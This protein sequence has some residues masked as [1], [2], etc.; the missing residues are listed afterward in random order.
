MDKRIIVNAS[1][2]DRTSKKSNAFEERGCC[3]IA[4]MYYSVY[5]MMRK[6]E[7]THKS[8][9]LLLLVLLKLSEGFVFSTFKTESNAIGR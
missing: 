2:I 4:E 3:V 9:F 7:Y 6:K 1:G 5:V 8:S